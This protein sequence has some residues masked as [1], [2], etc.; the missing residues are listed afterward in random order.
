MSESPETGRGRTGQRPEAEPSSSTR[1][2]STPPGTLPVQQRHCRSAGWYCQ[3]SV[4][5]VKLKLLNLGVRI[6]TDFYNDSILIHKVG[7]WL[8]NIIILINYLGYVQHVRVRAVGLTSF[9][10]ICSSCFQCL[11][12]VEMVLWGCSWDSDISGKI[13]QIQ[14][15]VSRYGIIKIK[16]Y[17]LNPPLLKSNKV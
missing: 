1:Y 16:N 17:F 3:V 10:R 8:R 13:H 7:F 11:V 12:I 14:D 2:C 5:N 4:C 9:C 15:F 6:A